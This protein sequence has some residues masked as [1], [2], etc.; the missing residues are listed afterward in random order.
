MC[1]LVLVCSGIDINVLPRTGVFRNRHQY[2]ASY[3][4]VQEQTSMCCLVLVCS[5]TD[6]N[7]VPRT[8]CVQ[9]R[10]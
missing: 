8:K 6:I 3:W 2:G 1:C 7:V 9:E 4:C 10:N 5:G